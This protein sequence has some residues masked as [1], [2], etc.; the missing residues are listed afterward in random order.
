MSILR[1]VE[2]FLG[3][4]HSLNSVVHVLHEG[5]FGATESSL[6]RDV[7]DVVVSFGVLTVG[8][9]DLHVEFVSDRLKEVFVFAELGKMDVHR[10]AK[11]SSEVGG[12]GSEVSGL[13]VDGELG[14]LFNFFASTGKSGKDLANIGSLLHGDDSELVLLIDPDK[15]SLG[16]VVED[17]SVSGPL[18]VQVAGFKEAITL[19]EE[20]VILDELLTL[21]LS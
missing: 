7:V 14:N 1:F 17:A 20:E 2:C 11:S 16:F 4:N 12:A 8:T 9:A 19:L 10:G 18:S 13:A 6:V 15:E 5:N 3:V 21:L